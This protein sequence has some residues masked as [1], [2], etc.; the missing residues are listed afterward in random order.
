M[1]VIRLL[2]GVLIAVI[3]GVALIPLMVL[4]DLR[5]GGTGWGLCADGFGRCNTSY[6]V[7]FE[8]LAALLAVVL[9]LVLAIGALVRLLRYLR[10]RSPRPTV[11][12]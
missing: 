1:I 5:D 10:D 6:F 9:A 3:I 7:G 12:R 2:I 11:A 4:L 8:L